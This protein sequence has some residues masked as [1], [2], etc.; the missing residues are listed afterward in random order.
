MIMDELGRLRYS[1]ASSGSVE[2]GD[3]STQ[4][5]S[6]RGYAI[7]T[8]LP[9][10]KSSDDLLTKEMMMSAWS[11]HTVIA[12]G[13]VM[14]TAV[15]FAIGTAHAA[16]NATQ[17]TT[18]VGVTSE[19]HCKQLP[20]S[21]SEFCEPEV[22][23]AMIS[24]AQVPDGK[25]LSNSQKTALKREDARYRAALVACKRMPVSDRTTCISEAGDDRTLVANK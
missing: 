4:S 16:A 3:V 22:G 24:T 12:A 5:S 17:S 25:A 15:T 21:Q 18:N 13:V 6:Q 14:A 8:G 23:S 1:P 10:A 19:A 20:M 11:N 7:G 9:G 2:S